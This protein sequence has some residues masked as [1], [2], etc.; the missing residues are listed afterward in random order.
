LPPASPARESETPAEGSR[1]TGFFVYRRL[2]AAAYETPLVEEPLERRALTDTLVPVGARACY[3]VRAVA[4][5]QPLVESSPSSEACVEV[6]DVTPPVPPAGL[7]V[8][9]R[10]GGL[11]ILW[12][13]SAEP[14]LAG[15]RVYRAGP[16]GEPGRVAEVAAGHASWLDE[17]A[18][19]GVAYRYAVS[20]VD[21]AGNESERTEPVEATLP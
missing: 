12:S 16:G 3:V 15:Y 6:R 17:K 10:E 19:R 21:Q 20:A 2:G 18:Q 13:P 7:A 8:L 11:D 1:T 5:T 14:D 4:S 9:P